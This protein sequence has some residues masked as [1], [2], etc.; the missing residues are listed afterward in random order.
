[1]KPELRVKTDYFAIPHAVSGISLF[2]DMTAVMTRPII[3]VASFP[4][5]IYDDLLNLRC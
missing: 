1:L 2:H 3:K 5:N 4:I